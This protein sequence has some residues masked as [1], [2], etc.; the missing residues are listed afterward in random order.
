MKKGIG[1]LAIALIGIVVA[2]AVEGVYLANFV[3]R[4]E[5]STRVAGETLIVQSI[6]ELEFV[7]R[8]L[9]PAAT[10]S[11]YQASYYTASRG[12]Y[13]SLDVQSYSCI[14]YWRVYTETD[15]PDYRTRLSSSLLSIFSEYLRQFDKVT[16]PSFTAEID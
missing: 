4:S 5:F 6:N 14:P 15:Y 8:A 2:I 13:D 7:K 16:F 3:I 12:G 1:P 10:Y 9:P 11:Y